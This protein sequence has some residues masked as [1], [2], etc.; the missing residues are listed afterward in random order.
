[1]A[2]IIPSPF[3]AVEFQS[4]EELLRSQVLLTNQINWIQYN[5]SISAMERLA[6]DYDPTNSQKFLQAEAE[7]KGKI[8]ILQYLLDC[9]KAA[10]E[11]LRPKSA[12]ESAKQA[13]GN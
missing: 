7:L 1:M 6:L 2:K 8:G 9:S 11:A 5:I 13:Q 4:D 10:E 3:C 12:E